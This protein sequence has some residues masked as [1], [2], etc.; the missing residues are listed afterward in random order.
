MVDYLTTAGM[1]ESSRASK[2]DQ[3]RGISGGRCRIAKAILAILATFCLGG[4]ALAQIEG[5]ASAF[6]TA[7]QLYADNMGKLK[8]WSG[9][10]HLELESTS[11]VDD[12]AVVRVVGDV[13]YKWDLAKSRNR[14]EIRTTSDTLLKDGR[15][16][17]RLPL[18]SRNALLR[19]GGYY[20]VIYQ[21]NAKATV[22]R[23][24]TITAQPQYQPGFGYDSFDP[25]YFLTYMGIPWDDYWRSLK[26]GEKEIVGQISVVNSKMTYAR[27]IGDSHRATF[28]VDLAKGGNVLSI[29]TSVE[30]S[31][32]S[33]TSQLEI[34][35]K[36]INA[37]WVPSSLTRTVIVKRP[38]ASSRNYKLT[39]VD[40]EVNKLIADD[41]F[42]LPKL[43]LRRGDAIQD[44]RSGVN[45]MA[46]GS[47]FPPMADISTESAAP[48]RSSWILIFANVAV[49]LIVLSLII[50]RW[51]KKVV[52]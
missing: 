28:V 14:Y 7:A 2:M 46:E 41:E 16:T 3:G 25:V 23:T 37:V 50:R 45:Y 48:R 49:V 47:E 26:A 27:Q 15:E 31:D 9:N 17:P 44:A 38:K 43:G 21:L 32:D 40:Q 34:E 11:E 20:S 30:Q 4:I 35:W 52:S 1:T 33:S 24:A 6:E 19:D 10:V 36:N 18:E 12:T 29:A 5:D 22:G 39:W 8:T 51:K 13:A 42:S